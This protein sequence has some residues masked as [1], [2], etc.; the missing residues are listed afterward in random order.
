MKCKAEEVAI[1]DLMLQSGVSFGTSGARGLVTAMTDRICY[2][3][4]LG[5]LQYLQSRSR[6]ATGC[7]V[8]IA[9]DYRPSTGRI[10]AATAEAVNDFGGQPINCGFIPT[11]ALALY[12]LDQGIASLMVTGSHIPDD[13]NGIKF[14]QPAGEIL[15]QDEAGIRSQRVNI[16]G[17]AFDAVGRKL[18][19]A[20]LPPEQLAAAAAYR[21][22][23][24][25]FFP[26]NCLAGMRVGLY[27]HSSVAWPLVS[28]TLRYFCAGGY[29]SGASSGRQSGPTLVGRAGSA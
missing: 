11:P 27:Q 3:Y 6:I 5:F 15:K 12:G 26:E 29:R 14:N 10:M 24:L 22:R 18:N 9:G 1:A 16:P 17:G 23:Y 25:A 28:G 7:R 21:H 4:T 2:A 8:A 19:P 13:R 20:A